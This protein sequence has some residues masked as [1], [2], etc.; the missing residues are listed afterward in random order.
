MNWGDVL[1]RIEE[2]TERVSRLDQRLVQLERLQEFAAPPPLDVAAPARAPG[3]ALSTPRPEAALA[4]APAQ[5]L[6]VDVASL[7]RG[8]PQSA[9]STA[10]TEVAAALA[11][12]QASHLDVV[13]PDAAQFALSTAPTEV[14]AVVPPNQL[15][16]KRM[17]EALAPVVIEI[18]PGMEPP[19]GKRWE[20]VLAEHWLVWL[21]G[22][23]LALGGAFLVKLSID[24]GLLTPAVRVI[25]AALL[26][27]GMCVAADRVARSEKRLDPDRAGP[28]Y[29]P[30]ALAAAGAATVFAAIYAAYQ[31]YDLIPQT[32]AFLLLA[33]TSATTML[34]SLRHGPLVAALGLVGAYVVPL[35]VQSK[36][37]QALPLFAYLFVVAEASLAL[38]RYRAWWWLAWLSL[39]GVVYW[40]MLWLIVMLW[41][42][43]AR[44]H[45]ESWVVGGFLLV[46]LT[47]FA[48]LRRGL[49][50]IRFLAG[51]AHILTV[52]VVTRVAFWALA[53]TI[54]IFVH[55]DGFGETSLVT[56][57]LAALFLLGFAYRDRDLDD[58]IAAAGALLLAVLATWELSLRAILDLISYTRAPAPAKSWIFATTAIATA[59]LLGGGGFVALTRAVR[60]GRWAVL[61]AAA[62]AL[63]VIIACWRLHALTPDIGWSTLALALAGLEFAAAASV[64]RCH[65]G[66]IEI[67]IALGAYAAGV[68]G[69]TILAV[70]LL[71][72]NQIDL[73]SSIRIFSTTAV[74]TALLSGGGCF[75]ALTQVRP[76]RWAAL[77]AAASALVLIIAY[78]RLRA[79]APD[80]G[81]STLA[82]AFAG[83]EVAAAASVARRRNG[84]NEIEVALGAYTIGAFGGTILGAT[85]AL[86][87]AW[88][89]LAL[90]LHLPAMGWVEGRVRLPALRWLAL[91]VAAAVLARLVL[92]PYVLSYPLSVTPIFNWLLYGYGV[93]AFAFIVAARQFGSRADDIVVAVL[94]AG[95]IIFTMMLL[96]LELR[97]ALYGRLDAPLS[98]LGRD[99]IQTVLWLGLAAF[100]LWLGE[101]RGRP[102]LIGGGISLFAAASAQAIIW[103][104][105]VVDP[106]WTRDSVGA[107]MI[108]DTI[109]LAYGLP[110]LVCAAI[111]WLRLG[112][113]ALRWVARSLAVGLAFLWLT[114][115]IRHAFRGDIITWGERNQ[116]EWYAYSVAWLAFAGAGLAVGLWRR[117]EWL[118]RAALLA[119]G[120]VAAK[121]F[122][123][124]MAALEGALRALSFL[125]LGGA[126][127]G[128]GHAYR[129]LCPLPEGAPWRKPEPARRQPAMRARPAQLTGGVSRLED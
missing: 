83:L 99:A 100:L 85:F 46:Q 80:I 32:L 120:L 4:V 64:A 114:L 90:A 2:L 30:Q 89:T 56:A 12:A 35:L 94:E 60:P 19:S 16:P 11:S 6:P 66:D 127:V 61:S 38:L 96:T 14:P 124:D 95:S 45:P 70:T 53:F 79:L 77:S 22:I 41:L 121:V 9:P 1:L 78:W 23:A 33:A 119:I 17:P 3:S 7:E 26:G 13:A 116:W 27:I 31:L 28:S 20:Q 107:T 74:A 118:R 8:A 103:Q 48:R 34:M 81:W 112:P 51:V 113:V 91:G 117:D 129:R 82:L 76:G 92:N 49:G 86:S 43:E 58:V 59:L 21:G 18:R 42:V 88:Q 108:L 47:L 123:S 101:R 10:L 67:E 24:Y 62:P 39:A 75:I 73:I 72:A 115:E 106:L 25:L 102:V 97:H 54:F 44:D 36:T 98:N 55:V 110:A 125:G 15:P 68:F 126:L 87:T 40:V 122:V 52:R 5:A 57:F 63:V 37:P 105:F 128:I 109:G 71:P 65:S 50:R 69:G 111:A 29:V 93:P 84:D 104:A